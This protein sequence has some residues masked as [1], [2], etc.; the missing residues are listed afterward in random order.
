MNMTGLN[1]AVAEV[2]GL[3]DKPAVQIGAVVPGGPAEK[4]GLKNGNVIVRF[5]GEALERGDEPQEVPMILQRK[6]RRMKPGDALKLSVITRPKEEPK[7][8]TITLLEMPK[9]PNLARR[10]F[11]EDLGFSVREMVF[12]DTYAQRLQADAKGVIVAL[13]RPQ[14][15][16]QT[17]GLQQNDVV[18]EINREPVVDLAQAQTSYEK[19]RKEKPT[20]A[21]VMVVLRDGATKVIRIEPPQ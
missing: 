19:F 10:Y 7:D 1:E 15:A 17:G 4:A 21:V 18:T 16:A 12:Q 20:E 8:V 5:N 2:Y 13:V 11:A 6:L 3:K 14:S 9:R